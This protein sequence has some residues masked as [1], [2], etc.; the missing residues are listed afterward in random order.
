VLVPSQAEG[1]GLS[2]IEAIACGVPVLATPVAIHPVALGGIEGAFCA[3]YDREAWRAALR[4]PLADPDPRLEGRARAE[5]FSADR[6]AARVVAAWR[7]I[8]EERTVSPRTEL[9]SE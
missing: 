2:V 8:V 3:P 4:G 9:E 6:M 1:F 7:D 5:V